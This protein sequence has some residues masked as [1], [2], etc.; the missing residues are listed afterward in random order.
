MAVS[1]FQP[2][3]SCRLLRKTGPRLWSLL[4]RFLEAERW[5]RRG[6]TGASE[7]SAA[8]QTGTIANFGRRKPNGGARFFGAPIICYSWPPWESGLPQMAAPLSLV[9]AEACGKWWPSQ[10]MP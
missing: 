8:Q 9:K 1:F 10:L 3:R 6:R 2:T 4:G 7:L 5:A